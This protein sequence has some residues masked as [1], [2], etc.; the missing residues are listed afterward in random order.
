MSCGWQDKL[1]VYYCDPRYAAESCGGG[2]TIDKDFKFS[3][4]TNKEEKSVLHISYF[5]GAQNAR[6]HKNCIIFDNKNWDC[7]E[8]E[9]LDF[10]SINR[11]LLM[12]NGIFTHTSEI[13]DLAKGNLRN[14]NDKGTCAK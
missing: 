4:V 8:F 13:R 11:K 6:T 3:F 10:V 1:D 12:A 2:C 14:P 7:S 5:E 9:T